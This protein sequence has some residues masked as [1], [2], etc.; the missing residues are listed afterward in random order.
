MLLFFSF[1]F[2][3][4][5]FVF[6]PVGNGISIFIHRIHSFAAVDEIKLKL[7]WAYCCTALVMGTDIFN[8]FQIIVGGSSFPF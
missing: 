1:Y 2:D 4:K 3:F 8:V 7:G 6:F 5:L